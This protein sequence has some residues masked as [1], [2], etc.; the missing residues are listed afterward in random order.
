MLGSSTAEALLR[1]DHY[2]WRGRG[3]KRGVICIF[4]LSERGTCFFF[5]F[6]KTGSNYRQVDTTTNAKSKLTLFIS[7][8][9]NVLAPFASR[10]RASQ[11]SR[12][13][14]ENKRRAR[15]RKRD[16][17]ESYAVPFE[18]ITITVAF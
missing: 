10:K 18:T 7:Y 8:Q 9:Y 2:L 11:V 1:T 13:I 6:R 14:K 5:S 17:G 12:R 16:R 15:K 4:D 3:K